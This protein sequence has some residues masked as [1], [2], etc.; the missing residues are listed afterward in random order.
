[1]SDDRPV[2]ALEHAIQAAIQFKLPRLAEPTPSALIGA[3][4]PPSPF[5]PE[6]VRRVLVALLHDGKIVMD[7]DRRL[8]WAEDPYALDDHYER[9]QERADALGL[10]Q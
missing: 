3:L 1:M 6:D 4:C 9:Q 7:D 5:Q 10:D 8:S 2:P